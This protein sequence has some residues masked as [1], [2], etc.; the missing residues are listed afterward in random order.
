MKF[1]LGLALLVL[2][3]GAFA[4][5]KTIQ[6]F[7]LAKQLQDAF[8]QQGKKSQQTFNPAIECLKKYQEFKRIWDEN[9][10]GSSKKAAVAGVMKA[11]FSRDQIENMQN[12]NKQ[13]IKYQIRGN[14]QAIQ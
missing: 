14:D 11:K 3:S 7:I 9:M 6:E 5:S 12:D 1:S 10:K 4:Q 2:S 13:G 8:L